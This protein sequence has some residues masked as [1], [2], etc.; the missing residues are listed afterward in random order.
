MTNFYKIIEY[1]CK[2]LYNLYIES[3]IIRRKMIGGFSS[4]CKELEEGIKKDFSYGQDIDSREQ[5]RAG[6]AA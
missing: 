4:N 2:S 6:G 3:P 5:H 1:L